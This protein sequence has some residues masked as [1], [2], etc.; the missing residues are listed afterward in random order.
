M[1]NLTVKELKEKLQRVIDTLDDYEDNDTIETVSN[2]YFIK[3]TFYAQVGSKGFVD[4]EN[5]ENKINIEDE[6]E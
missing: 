3:S 2:T 5:I 6:D 1:S 4:L